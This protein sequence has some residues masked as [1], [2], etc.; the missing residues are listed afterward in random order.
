[1]INSKKSNSTH[2]WPIF[3]LGLRILNPTQPNLTQP[4]PSLNPTQLRTLPLAYRKTREKFIFAGA[5][6]NA[7]NA[8]IIDFWL[9]TDWA[10]GI[11]K[12]PGNL[13]K[14]PQ[15]YLLG[16]DTLVFRQGIRVYIHVHVHLKKCT[17]CTMCTKCT[18]WNT[19]VHFCTLFFEVTFLSEMLS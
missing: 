16:L 2:L 14:T 6:E 13:A 1:M 8:K 7:E 10:C 3:Q 19:N 11:T 4:N 18:F 15:S 12:H 5:W 9:F 17:K